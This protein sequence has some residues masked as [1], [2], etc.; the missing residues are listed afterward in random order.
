MLDDSTGWLYGD[1]V[2]EKF[3]MLKTTDGAK[4]WKA[5]TLPFAAQ[6]DEGGFAS[7]GTCLNHNPQGDIAIG[8]GNAE[9]PRLLI[10]KKDQVWQ[11]IPSPYAGGEAAG[12]FS[13]QFDDSNLYTF[14]GSL[15]TKDTRAVGY[16][17]SLSKSNWVALPVLPFNGAIYGSANTAEYVFISNPEGIAVLSKN[18]E[19]SANTTS[20]NTWRKLSDL[21][22]W[23]MA[24]K[25][26]NCWGVGAN[27][28]VVSI[29]W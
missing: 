4:S 8:T 28:T 27:G 17:Y 29:S 26:S 7:S 1:S 20:K 25:D 21:D 12:I 24:C 23:A 3:S 18:E 2:N 6:E 5:V 19:R 22:I 9:S 16:K 15:K 13:V 14:G 11:S 10:K